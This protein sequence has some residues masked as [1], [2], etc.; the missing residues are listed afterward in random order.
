M[1]FRKFNAELATAA[2]RELAQG[3]LSPSGVAATSSLCERLVVDGCAPAIASGLLSHA[4]RLQ[5]AQVA[6]WL[7]GIAPA[8]RETIIMSVL[9]LSPPRDFV[10]L[11]LTRAARADPQL[12]FLITHKVFAFGAPQSDANLASLADVV[13]S[14]GTAREAFSRLLECWADRTFLRAA[15]EEKAASTPFNAPRGC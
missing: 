2:V 10:S 7:A 4:A 9:S 3:R 14:L 12:R 1:I 6:D 11:L 5:E 13:A 15:S 8:R